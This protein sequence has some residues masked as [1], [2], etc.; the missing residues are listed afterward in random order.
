MPEE[1]VTCQQ[2]NGKPFEAPCKVALIRPRSPKAH[3]TR[4]AVIPSS[5]CKP[6]FQAWP[7]TPTQLMH[8]QASVAYIASYYRA[9]ILP[10]ATERACLDHSSTYYPN[11]VRRRAGQWSAQCYKVGQVFHHSLKIITKQPTQ[12]NYF[13]SSHTIPH[14]TKLHTNHSSKWQPP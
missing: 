4:T 3:K 1:T 6:A 14:S 7:R 11:A 8:S 10:E 12:V 13:Q 2:R 5:W 9:S